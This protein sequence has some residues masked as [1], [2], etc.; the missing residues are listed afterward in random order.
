[1]GRRFVAPVQHI[2]H[3]VSG[4]TS[5]VLTWFVCS[6]AFDGDGYPTQLIKCPLYVNDGFEFDS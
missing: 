6:I 3:T 1:M 5:L 4:P 2:R